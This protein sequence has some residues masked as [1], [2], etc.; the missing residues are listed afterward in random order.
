[1]YHFP[2]MVFFEIE[3]LLHSLD[4]IQLSRADTGK[5]RVV[6][7]S[8]DLANRSVPEVAGKYERET[9][10]TDMRDDGECEGS[11][12]RTTYMKACEKEERT[13]P[14]RGTSALRNPTCTA[15]GR[16]HHPRWDSLATSHPISKNIW[17][18]R[19]ASPSNSPSFFDV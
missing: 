19:L 16:F 13:F 5:G 11:N 8:S 10:N 7:S 15:R 9:A 12:G 3:E 14:S 18:M 17:V 1:M 6:A 2:F 4:S